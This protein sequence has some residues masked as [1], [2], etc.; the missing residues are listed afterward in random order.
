[1]AEII[2]TI[3]VKM[4]YGLRTVWAQRSSDPFPRKGLF[5]TWLS[6]D[7]AVIEFDNGYME[8]FYH[9]EFKFTDSE[10]LF[11]EYN[12]PEKP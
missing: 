7:R 2:K 3:E 5:H 11:R 9:Y 12:W 1:M 10:E 8:Q 6:N 4:K